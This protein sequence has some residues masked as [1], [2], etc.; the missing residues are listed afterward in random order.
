MSYRLKMKEE[1]REALLTPMPYRGEEMT[2]AEL[3][4]LVTF[5]NAQYEKLQPNYF[6]AY[7]LAK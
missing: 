3:I 1:G 2:V 7:D 4:D 5:L 6:S